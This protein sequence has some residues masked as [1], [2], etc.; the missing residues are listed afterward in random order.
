[1]SLLVLTLS[2]MGINRPRLSSAPRVSYPPLGTNEL[3]EHELLIMT[4]QAYEVKATCT[5]LF[6]A[7]AYIRDMSIPFFKVSYESKWEGTE[8][9]HDNY[10]MFN[11]CYWGMSRVG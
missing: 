1:M 5:S 10:T 8:K 9:L 7:S 3:A 4:A 6:S 2:E 11:C